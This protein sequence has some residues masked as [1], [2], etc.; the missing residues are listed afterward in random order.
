MLVAVGMKS[1]AADG[2]PRTE[3]SQWPE[4]VAQFLFSF[5]ALYLYMCFTCLVQLHVVYICRIEG[6]NRPQLVP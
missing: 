1:G 6:L 5:K 4:K 2:S 3:E